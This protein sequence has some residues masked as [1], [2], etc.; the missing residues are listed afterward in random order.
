LQPATGTQGGT[1]QKESAS[2]RYSK[3]MPFN[4]VRSEHTHMD[5]CVG[6][7]TH[8]SCKVKWLCR[9]KWKTNTPPH[10]HTAYSSELISITPLTEW[11]ANWELIFTMCCRPLT[12]WSCTQLLELAGAHTWN[13]TFK[14]TLALEKNC[15]PV[16]VKRQ[17]IDPP[18][19]CASQTWWNKL[20]CCFPQ[21][22]VPYMI[23]A[24]T[25]KY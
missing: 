23:G 10:T 3:Q 12:L 19:T 20:Q 14:P 4:Q 17:E 8:K 22:I 21:N 2:Q 6:I 5:E 18:L 24:V 9:C 11:S 7:N 13:L 1:K 16:A 15:F 25:H